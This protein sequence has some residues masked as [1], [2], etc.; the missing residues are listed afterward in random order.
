MDKGEISRA[1]GRSQ[2]SL[3]V[4]QDLLVKGFLTIS[5]IKYEGNYET[6]TK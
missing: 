4:G 3:D 5:L 1:P 2:G 6:N